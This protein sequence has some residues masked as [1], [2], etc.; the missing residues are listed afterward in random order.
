MADNDKAYKDDVAPDGSP[1]RP[2]Y[3][4]KVMFNG[5]PVALVVAET[6]E[7][8]TFAASLVRVEYDEEKHETDLYRGRAAAEP[9]AAPTSPLEALFAPPK[10]RGTPDK[11]LAAAPVRHDAEYYVPIEHHNPMELYTSTVIW[12]EGGKLTVHDKTQGVQ[13]VQHYLCGVFDMKSDDVRVMSPFMGGGFGSGL[14]PQFQAVLAGLAAR[15][16]KRSVRVV[17]T[18]AQMYMA[19]DTA[20]R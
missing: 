9:V 1:Y 19:W 16:L 13:N 5:Q 20:R 18:R 3:D 2:L 11:A 14:R 12:E 8:A 15:A 4:N 17:L 6:S 10:E 7:A